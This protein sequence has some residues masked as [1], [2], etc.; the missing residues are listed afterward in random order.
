M[1]CFLSGPTDTTVIGTSNSFSKTG[2]NLPENFELV[3]LEKA[4]KALR[5]PFFSS[6]KF[7]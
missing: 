7:T 2:A 3:A 1:V 6:R 4:I 5:S